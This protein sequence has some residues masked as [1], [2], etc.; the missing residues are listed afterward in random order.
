[1]EDALTNN[2]IFRGVYEAVNG[3]LGAEWSW[4]AYF[5][6]G[7][8]VI[9]LV[10]NAFL[11]L[12]TLFTWAERK[13]V[14]RIQ[15][16]VGPNRAG[17]FG[18]LQ[19]IADAIKLLFKEDI[20]PSRADRIIFNL[21]PIVMLGASVMALA[22][23][24]FGRNSFIADLNVAIL[25]VV[26]MSGLASLAVLMAGYSSANRL[27]MF[28]SM[29]AVAML[30]SYEIPL[31]MSLLGIVVLAGS[32]SMVTIVEAQHIPYLLVSPLGVI[33]FLIA[34]SAELNRPPFDVTEA[35]S[36]IVAG[37]LTEYSGMK[38]GVFYLAEFANVILAGAIFA[39]LFLQGYEWGFLPSHVWF[40]L[41]VAAFAGLAS[42]LRGTLPRMRLDQV[43]TFA[44]KFLFPLSLINVLALV[45]QILVWP[46]PSAG[47]LLIMSAINWGIA[48]V[49]IV[50]LSRVVSLR[51]L[52]ARQA[53]PAPAWVEVR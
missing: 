16:R 26:A 15:S 51:S 25:Y 42:W 47:Q 2:A 14:G 48:I 50:V 11:L 3:V 30:V 12:G 35:E 41:K 32:M 13:I 24:P 6:G 39:V 40:I 20:V 34:I 4:L 33:V 27:A 38:F 7:M 1:M 29:R 36:E 49:A 8:A 23:I 28:G 21:A 44:W 53:P 43:L 22:V 17:P 46:E 31:V 52:P 37:Y 5:L 10:V 45:V 18:I 19:A 9:M